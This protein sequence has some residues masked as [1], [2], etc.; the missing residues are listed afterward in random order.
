L[1]AGGENPD[2]GGL[3]PNP[4]IE[5]RGAAPQTPLHKVVSVG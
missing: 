5:G 4:P 1:V 3:P 2:L